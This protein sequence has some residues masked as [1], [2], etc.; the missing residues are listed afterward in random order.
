MSL[1][2]ARAVS[3]MIE[4]MEAAEQQLTQPAAMDPNA[5]TGKQDD[6]LR[7][8]VRCTLAKLQDELEPVIAGIT[9]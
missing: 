7:S 1:N 9:Q 4:Q 2:G 6:S 8:I 3:K 5:L